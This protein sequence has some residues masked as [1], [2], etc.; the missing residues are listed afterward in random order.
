VK[1]LLSR[2][3]EWQTID[4]TDS[5]GARMTARPSRPAAVRRAARLAFVTTALAAASAAPA[6]AQ[7]GAFAPSALAQLA[8][9]DGCVMQTGHDLDHGCART[10]A[11]ALARRVTLSPDQRNV[12]VASFGTPSEGTNGV[13]AFRRA[14]GTG[15]LSAVGCVTANGGDGRVGSEGLC[16]RGDALLGTSDVA[17]SPDGANAYVTSVISGGVTW[18]ARDP[19]TGALSPVGCVKD[20]P[21]RD[22]C[23]EV[24][25][26]AGA[27]AV[28]VSAD[29]RN[30]Y[31][32]AALSGALH[33]FRREPATGALVHV[34]CLSNT[35][36]DGTCEQ[37]PALQDVTDLAVAP[38]GGAVYAAGLS[39]AVARFARDPGTGALRETACLVADA[40]AGG[41]CRAAAGIIGAAGVAVSPD[42][43]DLYVA[44]ET[45]EAVTTF[46]AAADGSLSETGCIQRLGGVLDDR[47][48]LEPGCVAGTAVWAPV[49]VD[50]AADGRTVYAAGLDT[51]TAYRRNPLNG[52]LTQTACA[53]EVTSAPE[54]QEVRATAGVGAVAA[55]ADGRNVYATSIEEEAVSVFGAGVAIG[56][57]SLRVTRSNAVRVPLACPAALAR[58]CTGVVRLGR[59]AR[60]RGGVRFRLRPG[61]PAMTVVRVPAALRRVLARRRSMRATVTVTDA[62]GVLQ[63]TTKRVTLRR[64]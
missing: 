39:G 17:I 49:A 31:V 6:S 23:A 36:A 15:A 37:A 13:V 55:S 33:A 44:A 16:R 22:R 50:V 8:G 48:E 38:D 63:R 7:G 43:R 53:E 56:A 62:R 46:R 2:L 52:A 47:P 58:A 54:C 1:V 11:L 57:A 24:P 9:E 41:P 14:P 5:P 59:G 29:G 60:A 10:G 64:R 18:L 32:A 45:S 42:S 28:V 27:A 35:G 4:C 51:I 19:A 26:L 20:I 30:V 34:Q 3:D 21:R 61:A 40:P 25:Q 12:Y